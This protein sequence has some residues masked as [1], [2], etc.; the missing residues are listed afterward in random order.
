MNDAGEVLQTIYDQINQAVA[1]ARAFS[2]G[3]EGDLAG[4]MD[5]AAVLGL[6]VHE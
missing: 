3:Q 6:D 5:L 1:A 2:R 4:G